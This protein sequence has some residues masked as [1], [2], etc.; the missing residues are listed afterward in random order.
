MVEIYWFFY[1]QVYVLGFYL[2]DFPTF[3]FFII[4]LDFG[5]FAMGFYL[6]CQNSNVYK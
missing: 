6:I 1:N 3:T 2:F 5:Q 4:Y